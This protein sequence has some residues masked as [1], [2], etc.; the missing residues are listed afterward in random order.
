MKRKSIVLTCI[1]VFLAVALCAC[2]TKDNRSGAGEAAQDTVYT[3]S[4]GTYTVPAGWIESEKFSSNE[5]FFYIKEGIKISN[6]NPKSNI[7]IECGEN[8]YSIDEET[9]FR[10]AIGNVLMIQ[11]SLMPSANNIFDEY[12]TTTEQGD[13]LFV[14]T[15]EINERGGTTTDRQYYIVGD[16]RHIFIHETD[17]HD[18]V[19]DV[20]EVAE[21]IANSFAWAE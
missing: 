16:Y 17:F 2:G 5:K 7:S 15:I 21:S 13:S 20:G 6:K 9:S 8:D 12:S 18:E 4:F 3:K 1:V 11:L 19:T 14:F 10:K